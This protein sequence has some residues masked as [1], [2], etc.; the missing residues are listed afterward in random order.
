MQTAT[1]LKSTPA[2]SPQKQLRQFPHVESATTYAQ[3]VVSGLIDACEYVQLACK[4][5]LDDLEKQ[6][7]PNYPYY[8]DPAKAERVCRFVEMM[9]HVSGELQRQRIRLEPWQ[10]LHICAPWGWLRKHDKLRRFRRIY[11]EVPRKNG[12]SLLL[13]ALSLYMLVADGEKGAEVYTGA[14]SERQAYEVFRPARLMCLWNDEF[15][16]AFGI[17]TGAKN[18]S[19]LSSGSKMEALIGRP[20]DGSRPSYAVADEVH[21]H[22]DSD[23]IDTMLTGMG[24]RRQP[25]LHM[26]TTAGVDAGGPCYAIRD[27]CIKMLKGVVQNDELFSLIY[28]ID[29]AQGDDW[30]DFGVWRKANPNFGV[31]VYEDFLKS[32]YK[33][34]MNNARKQNIIRCKHLNVWSNASVG[35]IN[36]AFWERCARPEL[37][38]YYF[39]ENP[40]WIGVDLASRIDLAAVM[41]LFKVA[42]EDSFSEF[43]TGTYYLFG[44]YF[45][46]SE[47]IA[48]PENAHYRAWEAE[49]LLTSTPGY[50]IDLTFVEEE[51]KN[52]VTTF[53]VREIVYDPYEATRFF[54]DVRVWCPCPCIEMVQSPNNISEAMKEFEALYMSQKLLHD[55][56]AM[57]RWQASNVIL[58]S[59]V[60]K[61]FYPAKERSVNK[62]D[63]IVATMMA[64]SRAMIHDSAASVYE[65]RGLLQI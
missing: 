17:T 1:V 3:D 59:A 43:K 64:L 48:L 8:F 41:Y 5:H 23:L 33:D 11:V 31:S 50:R 47:T 4:R 52:V 49:G 56:N 27:E 60:N 42:D 6:S 20:P 12:K 26:I 32:Q 10:C 24:S 51:L 16:N 61:K 38:M 36:M 14:S 65:T 30:K 55:S 53:D 39:R 34:A 28:T 57:L 58:K 44:S 18:I 2:L 7:D 63:G 9:I 13:S 62:I 29:E 19:V 54:D 22:A 46:P 37:K 40:V 21:E 45:L 35:F 15:R 25:L